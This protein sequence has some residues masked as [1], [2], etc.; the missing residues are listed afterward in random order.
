MVICD[1]DDFNLTTTSNPWLSICQQQ[2]SVNALMW[3]GQ[4]LEY[5]LRVIYRYSICRCCWNIAT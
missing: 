5:R 1:K 4:T 3:E 2:P